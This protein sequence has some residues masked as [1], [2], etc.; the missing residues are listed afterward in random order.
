MPIEALDNRITQAFGEKHDCANIVVH[1]ARPYNSRCPQQTTCSPNGE[2]LLRSSDARNSTQQ[3]QVYIPCDFEI[4]LG[5]WSSS[6]SIQQILPSIEYT[7]IDWTSHSDSRGRRVS[8]ENGILWQHIAVIRTAGSWAVASK[9]TTIQ[10]TNKCDRALTI[11]ANIVPGK[12][13]SDKAVSTKAVS[14]VTNS[15]NRIIRKKKWATL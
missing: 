10:I 12:I 7:S 5:D 3:V 15:L 6:Q 4:K 13:V 1:R 8:T 2:S 14:S 9:S 11:R